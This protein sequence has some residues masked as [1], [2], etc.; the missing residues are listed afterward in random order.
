MPGNTLY[1]IIDEMVCEKSYVDIEIYKLPINQREVR[2][3]EQF[4]LD[5]LI[6]KYGNNKLA[7]RNLASFSL[8]L[9]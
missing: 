6:M 8:A 7:T 1:S 4:L 5:K 3:F 9:N 2:T